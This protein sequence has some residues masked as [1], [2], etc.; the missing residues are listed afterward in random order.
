MKNEECNKSNNPFKFL[1]VVISITLLLL[2]GFSTAQ[3]LKNIS[4]DHLDSKKQTSLELYT[5]AQEAYNMWRANTE[6]I[7]LLD[8]RTFVE[9]IFIGHAEMAFNIP[10]LHQTTRWDSSKKHYAMEL[11][12]DFLTQVKNW[13]SPNDTIL[14]M[15]RSGGRASPNDT[16]LVMCR[17]GGRSA[18]AINLLAKSGFKYLYNIVDGMEGD[19]VKDSENIYYMKRMKNGWKNSGI[20]WTYDINPAEQVIIQEKE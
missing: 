2:S 11:N 12:P 14:V 1:L 17:S 6:R 8:V 5:T 9:Y 3:D 7:K 15:C 20:P 16:I 19:M 4:V 10:L 13:A 18:M